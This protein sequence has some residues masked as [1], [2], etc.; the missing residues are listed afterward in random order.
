M[1]L[2]LQSLDLRGSLGIILCNNLPKR[3]VR[4]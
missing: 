3:E 2:L 1:A 4:C